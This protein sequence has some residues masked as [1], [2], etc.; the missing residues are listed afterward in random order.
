MVHWK[1]ISFTAYV[2]LVLPQLA[3][4]TWVWHTLLKRTQV[5]RLLQ[6]EAV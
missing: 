4:S 6:C 2:P 5:L 3:T 1:C